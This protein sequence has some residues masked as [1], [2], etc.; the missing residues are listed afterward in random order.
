MRREEAAIDDEKR[1]SPTRVKI[2]RKRGVKLN[3]GLGFNKMPQLP[4]KWF[5][6]LRACLVQLRG[7]WRRGEVMRVIFK[8]GRRGKIA[9]QYEIAPASPNRTAHSL[10]PVC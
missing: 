6:N 2:E 7:R 9:Q 3:K 10:L 5:K 8:K 4:S 1:E